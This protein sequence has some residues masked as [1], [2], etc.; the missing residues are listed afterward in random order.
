MRSFVPYQLPLAI[1][2]AKQTT[3]TSLPPSDSGKKS[4]IEVQNWYKL[5][6][7]S[8]PLCTFVAQKEFY[9]AED[10]KELLSAYYSHN[11]LVT[12]NSKM[13]TLD[14][15]ISHLLAPMSTHKTLSRDVLHRSLLQA[16]SQHYRII[17]PYFS[18]TPASKKIRSGPPPTILIKLETRNGKRATTKIINLQH[19]LATPEIQ[20]LQDRLKVKCQASVSQGETNGGKPGMNM[21]IVV[22]GKW[23]VQVIA[24]LKE[25]RLNKEW[26]KIEDMTK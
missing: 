4:Q 21:E 24:V 18:S 20:E 10:L 8:D 15:H 26:V 16:C 25:Q 17:N 19:Y 23:E 9:S 2:P 3:L 22:Q 11:N 7:K 14:T 5:P 12:E 6:A 13:I 1:D